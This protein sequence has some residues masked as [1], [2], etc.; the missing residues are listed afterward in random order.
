MA[1]AALVVIREMGEIK[2]KH[3]HIAFA[4]SGR[5]FNVERVG[6]VIEDEVCGESYST[7]TAPCGT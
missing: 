6:V 1:Q 5:N 2:G 7:T 4:P 3:H